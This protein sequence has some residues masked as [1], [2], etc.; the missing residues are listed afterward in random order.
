MFR[1]LCITHREVV[2][3]GSEWAAR[4]I[5]QPTAPL[6]ARN[7]TPQTARIRAI[8]DREELCR[9]SFKLRRNSGFPGFQN[10]PL[11]LTLGRPILLET[12]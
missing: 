7:S 4:R 5:L 11:P 10:N 8:T 12:A 9:G 1:T 2:E 3:T 6:L